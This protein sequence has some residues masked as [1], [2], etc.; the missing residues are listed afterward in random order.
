MSGQRLRILNVVDDVT[1]E[2]LAAIADTSISGHRVARELTSL[3]GRRGRP[4]I[5]VSDNVLCREGR[6]ADGHSISFRKHALAA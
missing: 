2:C 4:G 3:I 1:K 5:I 6:S